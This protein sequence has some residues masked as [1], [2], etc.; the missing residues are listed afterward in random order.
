MVI[1]NHVVNCNLQ[2]LL[3]LTVIHK[4][5]HTVKQEETS[6]YNATPYMVNE[7]KSTTPC[8]YVENTHRN[9]GEVEHI[10]IQWTK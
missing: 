8:Q 1:V 3:D 7:T 4:H 5:K 2:P 10:V 9:K 6:F